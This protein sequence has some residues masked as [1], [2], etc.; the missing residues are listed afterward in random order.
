MC[1]IFIYLLF[2]SSLIIPTSLFATNGSVLIGIGA[3]S[4]AMGGT[5]IGIS[6]GADS[7]LVNPSLIVYVN[8]N[9]ISLGGTLFMPE[10][11]NSMGQVGFMSA[12]K[13]GLADKSV[14][15]SVSFSTKIDDNFYLG[16]GMW[17]TAGM[18]VDYRNSV[19]NFN[20]V[21]NLQIMQFGVPL[22]YKIDNLS[23]GITPLV[24]YGSLDVSYNGVLDTSLVGPAT[25]EIGHD[26][27]VSQDL[28]IGYNIGVSY[29]INSMT[30]GLSYKSKI[31]MVYDGQLSGASTDFA[32]FGLFGGNRLGDE[33]STPAEIGI[34]VSYKYK[35][36]TI[37]VDI[38]QIK[39]SD[40]KG[41]EDFKWEDQN[42]FALGY[43]FLKDIWALRVGYN[44]GSSPINE[45]NT[46]TI[47]A[48]A[49]AI[50]M[51]NLLGF[52]AIV[53]SH[54][55]IGGA[56]MFSKEASLDFAYVYAPEVTNTY[57]IKQFSAFGGT[58]PTQLETKHS[59]SSLSVGLKYNF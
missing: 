59:Q 29:R 18:G 52:P 46:N 31:D 3:K 19:N 50:N 26:E 4:R 38:K 27:G 55:T 54:F 57:S 43:E 45:Q 42:V 23:I 47:D 24:Q 51:F 58:N 8:N 15:P 34:G 12:Y 14:I 7:A 44:Y 6:H 56:Y 20:M 41:Y 39:W 2:V 25:T 1:K 9:Q 48:T 32:S 53:E 13:D 49:S 5:G 17:G 37:A 35:Y 10:V 22:A 40:A 21:T 36:H 33:I 30:I 28:A 16:L 11:S